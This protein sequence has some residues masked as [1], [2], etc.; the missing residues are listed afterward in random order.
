MTASKDA[1]ILEEMLKFII[2]DVPIQDTMY[3]F[4]G[5]AANTHCRRRI[6]SYFQ[7]N[8]GKVRLPSHGDEKED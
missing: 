6:F 5:A 4:S 3:Y 1:E 7:E 8:Y 2:S